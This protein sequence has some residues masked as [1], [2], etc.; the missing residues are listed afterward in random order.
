MVLLYV[1]G[2]KQVQ[3]YRK[4]IPLTVNYSQNTVICA[5]VLEVKLIT[6]SYLSFL[7]ARYF[8]LAAGSALT[9]CLWRAVFS[10]FVKGL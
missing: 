9:R 5:K 6:I 10:F 1:N 7:L 4:R 3:Y 2:K 8:R